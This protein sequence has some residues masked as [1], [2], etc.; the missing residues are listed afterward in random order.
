MNIQCTDPKSHRAVWE[1]YMESL[2][3][4]LRVELSTGSHAE[5]CTGSVLRLAI[6]ERGSI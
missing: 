2:D 3:N 6:I 5:N 4:A 1:S